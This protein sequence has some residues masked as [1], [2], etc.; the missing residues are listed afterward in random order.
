MA[1]NKDDDV[2]TV[3]AELQAGI[4]PT[5]I[6]HNKNI[7]RKDPFEGIDEKEARKMKRKWRKLKKKFGV[8]IVDYPPKVGLG[9]CSFKNAYVC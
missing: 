1:R 2:E 6:F 5:S 9:G 7:E 3:L 8:I 4:I